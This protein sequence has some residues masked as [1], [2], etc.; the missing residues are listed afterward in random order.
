MFSIKPNSA[1]LRFVFMQISRSFSIVLTA[2]VLGS[3]LLFSS[4]EGPAGEVGPAGPQGATGAAGP[5]GATGATGQT[6]NANVIQISYAAKTWAIT[7][8][9]AQ[10]FIL[11]NITPAIM[12]SSAILIYMTSAANPSNT[13]GY[14]WYSIPGTVLST[15]LVEHEFYFQTTF[16][17]NTSGINVYRKIASA[18]TLTAT[19][20]IILIPANDLRNGRLTVDFNDYNAVKKYYNLKD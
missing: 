20:R 11:P 15:D 2:L 19:T 8:G 13:T 6:G 16:A 14:P 1:E 10:Q 18:S 17:G 12:N 9:S 7:R 4:C 5:Q 3:S